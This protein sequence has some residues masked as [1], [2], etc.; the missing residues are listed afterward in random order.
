MAADHNTSFIP[1]SVWLKCPCKQV[2][3]L[4]S[5]F[6][7]TA[8]RKD[9]VSKC[10]ITEGR[11]FQNVT[12]NHRVNDVIATEDGP[13]TLVGRFMYGPL[14]MV[15]LTGEKVRSFGVT[16]SPQVCSR[17]EPLTCASSF[18]W[19]S[20]WW[21][22]LS[23]ATGCTLTQRWPTAAAGSPTPFPG[24]KSWAWGSIQSKWWSS[25]QLPSLVSTLW[26]QIG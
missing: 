1:L 3:V 20:F 9:P 4:S 26:F 6:W 16:V 13:Q 23:L 10:C 14:D 12:A 2:P 24:A 21:H 17:P 19:T 11:S 22:S 7:R 5:C 15:T 8:S 25:T 18:R